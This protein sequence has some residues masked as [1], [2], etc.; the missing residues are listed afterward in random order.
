MISQMCGIPRMGVM[1]LEIIVA[2]TEYIETKSGE[3]SPLVMYS[4]Y[5]AVVNVVKLLKC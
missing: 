2:G 5:F 1:R 3:S 4:C